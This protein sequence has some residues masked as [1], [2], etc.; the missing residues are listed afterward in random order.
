MRGSGVILSGWWVK[1]GACLGITEKARA[2]WRR[3]TARAIALRHN[4]SLDPLRLHHASI[5]GGACDWE[6]SCGGPGCA[7]VNV[8]QAG[9]ARPRDGFDGADGGAVDVGMHTRVLQKLAAPYGLLHLGRV[10]EMIVDAVD[11]PRPGCPSRVRDAEAETVRVCLDET[12]EERAL[13]DA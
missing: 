7:H 9:L 5:P 11:L 10:A 4:P 6:R 1:G 12:G 3:T 8:K 13:P 2:H